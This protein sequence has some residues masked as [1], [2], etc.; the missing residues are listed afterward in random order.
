[1][2]TRKFTKKELIELRARK[3]KI[4]VDIEK[5]F[6]CLDAP[7]LNKIAG[8]EIYR[9]DKET[10][11]ERLHTRKEFMKATLR[12]ELELMDVMLREE[13]E[14][15]VN[16]LEID[17]GDLGKFYIKDDGDLGISVFKRGEDKKLFWMNEKEIEIIYSFLQRKMTQEIERQLS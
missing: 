16:S 5:A 7:I 17:L 1:M 2:F 11:W 3:E 9:T 10:G 15:D 6:F 13:R 8:E 12:A 4:I 14:K